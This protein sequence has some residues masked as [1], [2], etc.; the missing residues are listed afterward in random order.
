VALFA[1]CVAAS[2]CGPDAE[3]PPVLEAHGEPFRR[4]AILDPSGEEEWRAQGRSY[5]REGFELTVD[6][7]R[8]GKAAILALAGIEEAAEDNLANVRTILGLAADRPLDAVLVAGGV[9][10]DERQ[11]R[12]ILAALGAARAPVLVS[13]GES[14]PLEGFRR[15]LATARRRAKN[16]VDMSRVRAARLPD[17]SV[18]SLPGYHEPHYLRHRAEGCGVV[19]EDVRLLARIAKGLPSPVVLLSAAPPRGDGRA[20]IDRA[21]GGVNI[22]SR[23]LARALRAGRFRFGVFGHVYEAGGNATKDDG[24]TRVAPGEASDSLLVNPGAAE[25]IPYDLSTGGRAQG[26]GALVE[27]EGGRARYRV[28]RGR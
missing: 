27:I 6:G 26:I 24:R 19:P 2:A 25:A 28:L 10:P 9:G 16:L 22:G 12:V 5:R 3:D 20:A 14:E 15:A 17:F 4:C 1:L 8:D 23:P 7:E 18:V 13:I 21:R 11:A